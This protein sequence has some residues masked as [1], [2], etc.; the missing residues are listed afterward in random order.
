MQQDAR[1]KAAA[2]SGSD[3]VFTQTLMSGAIQVFYELADVAAGE[4]LHGPPAG[5]PQG[6]FPTLTSVSPG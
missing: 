3:P 4:G 5:A 6:R 2:T 1:L